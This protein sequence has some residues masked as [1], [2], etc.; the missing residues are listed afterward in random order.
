MTINQA[1]REP[2]R[3]EFVK[4]M[5]KEIE[6]HTQQGHWE[7][8]HMSTIPSGNK[9]ISSVWSM[10][11]NET[12]QEISSSGRQDNVLTEGILYMECIIRTP[13][14]QWYPGVLCI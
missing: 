7:E 9:P 5:I 4:A 14:H 2:N 11:Q 1:L 6:D 12:W 10:K 8:V 13:T 3:E